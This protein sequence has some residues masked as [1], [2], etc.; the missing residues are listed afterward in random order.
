MAKVKL[1]PVVEQVRGGIGDLIFKRYGE[2][3][4]VA[5]KADTADRPW[6][7]AQLASRE[8]FRQA[9]LYG[10][11]M[12]AD[13]AMKALYD[14]AAKTHGKPVF[15]LTI[16]DFFNAPSVDEIDLSDY[17]GRA[18]NEIVI[19]ASDDFEVKDV[20]VA[21]TH[22]DGSLIESGAAVETPA[23]S[24]RWVYTATV[25][26]PTGTPVRIAVTATDRPGHQAVRTETKN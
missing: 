1:N 9:A 25:G 8:H 20:S 17:T 10:K 18:G 22:S 15:S 2:D 14:E 16:A 7:E 21:M 19:R 13:P 23:R 5:R 26:V 3:V 12:M 4:I 24:G 6:S 11:L